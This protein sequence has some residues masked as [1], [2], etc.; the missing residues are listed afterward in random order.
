M[1]MGKLFLSLDYEHHSAIY[2]AKSILWNSLLYMT[3]V[4]TV[5][6]VDHHGNTYFT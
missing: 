3:S 5:K 6:M 4:F 1:S 2:W